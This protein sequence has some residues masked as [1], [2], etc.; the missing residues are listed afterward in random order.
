MSVREIIPTKRP[1]GNCSKVF[2]PA[3]LTWPDPKRDKCHD[4]A[5]AFIQ[6]M[7]VKRTAQ[8]G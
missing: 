5:T 3:V 2:T 4:C 6:S 7:F 1:C 8:T